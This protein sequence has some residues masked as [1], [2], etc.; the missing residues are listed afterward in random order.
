MTPCVTESEGLLLQYPK[1]LAFKTYIHHS[2]S[3]THSADIVTHTHTHTQTSTTDQPA[4]LGQSGGAATLTIYRITLQIVSYIVQGAN[5]TS[6]T[7]KLG[8]IERNT[9]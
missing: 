4:I 2:P 7:F 8:I 1:Y 9:D 6:N 3:H 5:V